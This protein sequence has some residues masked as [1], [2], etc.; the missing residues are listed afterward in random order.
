VTHTHHLQIQR[1][2]FVTIDAQS[3]N[4]RYT[5]RDSHTQFVA[6][7]HPLQIPQDLFVDIDAQSPWALRCAM[8]KPY[9]LSKETCVLR[10]EMYS[11]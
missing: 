9:A 8:W 10:N 5:V 2:V 1:D 3:Q 7:T 11:M 6:H 4:T